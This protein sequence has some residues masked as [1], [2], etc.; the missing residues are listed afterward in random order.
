MKFLRLL[1]HE[2]VLG[3]LIAV[4]SVFTAYVSYQGSIADSGQNENEVKAMQQLNDGNA[5]YLSANQFIVYD[6]TMYDGWYTTDSED[7][8][9]YYEVNYSETL[10]NA[11]ATDPE[12]P[13]SDAY[14]EEMYASAYEL[15]DQSDASSEL[16]GQWDSRGDELQR[17]ML[18]V[19]LGLAFA[20][21]ASLLKEE[22]K[23]R[24]LFAVLAV[25]TLVA[26]VIIYLGVPIVAG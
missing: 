17:V 1:A 2:I 8:A 21:W 13:F 23:M 11:I 9:A 22:S 6:Y 24:L 10:Q 12:N 18:I 20:A 25:V 19:A 3:T 15:W 5:E 4:L 26:G 16:A 7:K 14:Y